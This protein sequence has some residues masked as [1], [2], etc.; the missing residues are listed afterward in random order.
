LKDRHA[1]THSDSDNLDCSVVKRNL[2]RSFLGVLVVVL[3]LVISASTLW[4]RYGEAVTTLRALLE[5]PAGIVPEGVERLD[6][7]MIDGD[8]TRKAYI[9]DPVAGA[10][11]V[12]LLVPGLTP[13]GR[14]DA[15]VTA[16]A[17][18]LA[19]AGFRT[20]VPDLPGAKRLRADAGDAGV[21]ALVFNR[22]AL[23]AQREGL[24]L[25]VVAISYG[26]GPALVALAE[27]ARAA[28]LHRYVGLGGY[29]DATAV[30]AFAT[31]GVAGTGPDARLGVPDPR[32]RWIVLKANADLAALASD[33]VA[34]NR[35]ADK[36]LWEQPPTMADIAVT[37]AGLQSDAQALLTFVANV[38][39][40]RVD[41]L[42]EALEPDLRASVQ[43]L[44]PSRFDLAA[45][46]GKLLLIHGD[47]D[48]I[49]PVE[50]SLALA[51]A[52]PGTT[53]RIV[54]GFSHIEPE[55]TGIAG[56]IAMIRAVRE[57]LDT[58]AL[59]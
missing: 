21:V 1:H 14:E 27:P 29:F 18:A 43:G 36:G 34:L 53:V 16:V 13:A 23:D 5:A 49:V 40:E 24:P 9:Y 28:M 30:L 59:P 47:V 35:L 11:A 2:R 26:Q 8:T 32:A 41:T 44:S 17:G 25:V 19:Q 52:V 51:D 31:T 57:L 38:Q 46:E 20:V 56:Q 4:H 33:R 6:L 3:V 15:R 10:R 37:M 12:L 45:L 58:R 7:T 55:S 54:P 50:E 39:P 48:P 22:F 42:L